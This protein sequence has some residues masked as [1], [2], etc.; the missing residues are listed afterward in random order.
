[1]LFAVEGRG[2]L[3]TEDARSGLT[4]V[5]SPSFP[6]PSSYAWRTMV[7]RVSHCWRSSLQRSHHVRPTRKRIRSSAVTPRSS[8]LLTSYSRPWRTRH[9]PTDH[10]GPLTT[11]LGS[12][13]SSFAVEIA[14]VGLESYDPYTTVN[15]Y[16][17]VELRRTVNGG[18]VQ[19]L[20]TRMEID[21]DPVRQSALRSQPLVEPEPDQQPSQ[22]GPSRADSPANGYA[23]ART[24]R[25]RS[26]HRSR[27]SRAI[28]AQP[29][30]ATRAESLAQLAF[31]V[32]D[33]G[34]EPST[35]A[36]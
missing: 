7:R 19:T 33:N 24:A 10:G 30:Q 27:H 34:L 23:P 11:L 13:A 5:L 26:L 29:R 15:L 25:H 35:S 4:L 20:E 31:S 9:N 32:G 36:V 8:H 16:Q 17:G 18:S 6:E 12:I 1:M 21:A 22:R 14:I 3:T 2:V 28:G